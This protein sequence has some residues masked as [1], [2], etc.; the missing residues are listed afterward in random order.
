MD[1]RTGA[2]EM[3]DLSADPHETHNLFDDP[4][5]KFMRARL[6][7]MINSRPDDMLPE[8]TPAGIA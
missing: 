7:E 5:A 1:L 2:G 3:C 4:A 6:Q 8:Q